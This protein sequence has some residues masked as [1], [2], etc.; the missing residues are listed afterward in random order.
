MDGDLAERA[1][2]LAEAGGQDPALLEA[3]L[4]SGGMPDDLAD[5]VANVLAETARF[6]AMGEPN[7]R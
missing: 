4:C 1:R 3:A 7:G 5:A 6:A 2:A